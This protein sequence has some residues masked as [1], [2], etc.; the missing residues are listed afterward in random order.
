MALREHFRQITANL[1][2]VPGVEAA[3]LL[4]APLP[5]QGSDTV[6]FW[7]DGEPKPPS[8]NDMHW[9]F[10]LGVQPDYL[11]VLQ[12]PLKQGRFISAADKVQSPLVIV[13]YE[14][15]ARRY[16]PNQNPLGRRILRNHADPG[17]VHS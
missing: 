3:S 7:L 5:M 13:I 1:E 8:E 17:Q 2:S 10:D 6:T 9:A 11:K 14:V 15:F 12:I 16:F 4:D